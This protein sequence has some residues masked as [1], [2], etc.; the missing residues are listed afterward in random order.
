MCGALPSKRRAISISII[1]QLSGSLMWFVCG[2]LGV[3]GVFGV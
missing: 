2:L 3:F 1:F